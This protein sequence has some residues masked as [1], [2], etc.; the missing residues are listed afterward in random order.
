MMGKITTDQMILTQTSLDISVL[1][2]DDV[3]RQLEQQLELSKIGVGLAA[4]QISILKRAF[5]VYYQGQKLRFAN[6]K[7][8]S[9]RY[10][11]W[12]IEGCLSIPGREFKIER[13]KRVIIK[14]D[15]NGTQEYRNMLARIIQH[16]HDH[17]QGITL[18]QSGREVQII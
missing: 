8:V 2:Y 7:I 6:S 3:F 1:E 12:G 11:D 10:P 18:L 4:P 5:I 13:F 14:D 16:E 15:I 17:T 9:G